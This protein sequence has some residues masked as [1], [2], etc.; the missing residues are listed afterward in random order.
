MSDL[1]VIEPQYTVHTLMELSTP[2]AA[3]LRSGL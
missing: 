1:C 3:I 2:A